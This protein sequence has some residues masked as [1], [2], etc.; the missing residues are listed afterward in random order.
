MLALRPAGE[1]SRELSVEVAMMGK[2][3]GERRD[4]TT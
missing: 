4:A 3:F 2:K 1:V